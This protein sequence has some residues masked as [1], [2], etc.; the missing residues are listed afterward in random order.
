MSEKKIKNNTP[1]WAI[2]FEPG[3]A[4]RLGGYVYFEIAGTLRAQAGDNQL[5]VVYE[6]IKTNDKTN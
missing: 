4:S 1:P 5:A 2:A 6:D 3:A